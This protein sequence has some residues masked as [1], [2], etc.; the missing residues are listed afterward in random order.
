MKTVLF[1]ALLSIS[2]LKNYG[3]NSKLLVD[4]IPLVVDTTQSAVYLDSTGKEISKSEWEVLKKKS[5]FFKVEILPGKKVMVKP[6]SK[7]SVD[8]AF[9]KGFHREA[10]K[11]NSKIKIGSLVPGFT[12]TDVANTKFALPVTNGKPTLIHFWFVD[13]KPCREE[14][15]LMAEIEKKYLFVQLLVISPVDTKERI[16]ANR[17]LFPSN[18]HL[19]SIEGQSKLLK[20]SLDIVA[21]PTN[22]LLDKNGKVVF[23]KEGAMI[24]DEEKK[25]F[26]RILDSLK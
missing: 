25:A 23:Y 24:K 17:H 26:F 4:T 9:L 13:C 12:V 8:S 7:S 21:Y 18:A 14:L 5:D 11:I 20:T 16:K 2:F 1:V 6:V 15:P 3:Q 22:I 10:T 19:V